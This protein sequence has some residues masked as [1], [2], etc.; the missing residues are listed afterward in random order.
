MSSAN[1]IQ[2]SFILPGGLIMLENTYTKNMTNKKS[3]RQLADALYSVRM[4]ATKF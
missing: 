2:I 3:I 1:T 4:I